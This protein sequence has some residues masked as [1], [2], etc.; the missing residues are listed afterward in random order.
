[1][2]FEEIRFRKENMRGGNNSS[3]IKTKKKPRKVIEA[4]GLV[5]ALFAKQKTPRLKQ[6]V[7]EATTER[8]WVG[9]SAFIWQLTQELKK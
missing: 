7:K 5:L 2:F 1:M 3:K 8:L 4:E 6:N 9:P